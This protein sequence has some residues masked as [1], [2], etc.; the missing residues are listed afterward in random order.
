MQITYTL[1]GVTF[2]W[3]AEKARRNAEKHG[4]TFEEAAQTFFDP[5]C[6]SGEASVM[7]ETRHVVLGYSQGERL[8]VVVHTDHR[9]ATRIISARLATRSERKLYEHA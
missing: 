9:D 7:G 6:Q 4:V 8:L 1:Q 5:F 2:H 3:D